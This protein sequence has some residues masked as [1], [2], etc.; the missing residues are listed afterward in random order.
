MPVLRCKSVNFGAEKSLG[1]PNWCAQ[2]NCGS[3]RTLH[4]PTSCVFSARTARQT[5]TIPC[6]RP[7][8]LQF[9]PEGQLNQ[10][11]STRPSK[12]QPRQSHLLCLSA[13]PALSVSVAPSL[14][15]S[16][17]LSPSLSLARAPFFAPTL[18]VEG[19]AKG[20]F[21]PGR[22]V[23]QKPIALTT[24]LSKQPTPYTSL[25]WIDLCSG[26]EAGS[27]LRLIDSCITQLKD[28][29]PSRTCD[30]GNKEEDGATCSRPGTTTPSVSVASPVAR[31]L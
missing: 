4:R 3:A 20:Q 8:Y 26:S 30:E 9:A 29:G 15:V 1:S 31:Q 12:D 2:I 28:Q 18:C 11:I 23:F 13:S 27:Y 21:V 25:V 16:V 17:S 5:H 19:V 6:S 22:A 24:A 7:N 10:R 14:S